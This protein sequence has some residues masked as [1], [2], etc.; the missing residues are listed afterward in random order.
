VKILIPTL[1]GNSG[2]DVYFRELQ[3]G[4]GKSAVSVE[5]RRFASY[6]EVLPFA[7]RAVLRCRGEYRNCALV[8]TNADYGATF[9]LSGKP[10]VVTAHHDVFDDLYQKYTT[11]AQK[12]YHYGLLK[13]RVAQAL[14]TADGVIAVS[15]ST[16][17]SL[18]RTF[19]AR[20]IDVI[21]NGVDTETFKPRRVPIPEEF[22]NKIRLLFV[23][24]LSKRKGADLLPQIMKC[25]GE[26]YVLF[27]TGG[28]QSRELVKLRNA[29]SLGQIPREKLSDIYNMCD[30]FL[31]PSRLEGF[32]YGVAEAM[33][34]GKPVV[35]TNGSSLPELVTDQKGG[36]LCERDDVR[37]FAEKIRTLAA[38]SHLRE[39]MGEFNRQKVLESFTLDRMAEDYLRFYR[40][41]VSAGSRAA[42]SHSE[43]GSGSRG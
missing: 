41:V 19:G 5:I 23:G 29:I 20:N 27:Y 31:F 7:A 25:I 12:T 36:Y 6:L 18:E 33:A 13:N 15:Y 2:S 34:C 1:R 28:P 42:G 38:D 37:D 16:K 8:H 40:G 3:T 43:K 9:K 10:Y 24:N 39:T 26:G 14:G 4:L 30:I 17:T 35:C 32:G 21:Y 11:V 22:G